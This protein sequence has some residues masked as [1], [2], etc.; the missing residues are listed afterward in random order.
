MSFVETPLTDPFTPMMLPSAPPADIDLKTRKTRANFWALDR[1]FQSTA[2][3]RFCDFMHMPLLLLR[4][5]ILKISCSRYKRFSN[6]PGPAISAFATTLRHRDN[7]T[8][9]IKPDCHVE[10]L[11]YLL[12]M[13]MLKHHLFS[14]PSPEKWFPTVICQIYRGTACCTSLIYSTS[15]FSG[16]IQALLRVTAWIQ[17]SYRR[18]ALFRRLTW[19]LNRPCE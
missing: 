2:T 11:M 1:Q 6:C 13:L 8:L 5:A 10:L 17:G 14:S 15:R 12:P 9:R 4:R 18:L 19:P 3:L 7:V 16:W